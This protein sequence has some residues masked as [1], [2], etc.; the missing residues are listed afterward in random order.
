MHLL[1]LTSSNPSCTHRQNLKFVDDQDRA[2]NF[3]AQNLLLNLMG[4]LLIWNMEYL[5]I[6]DLNQPPYW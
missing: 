6:N 3:S 4:L 5:I 2:L 1:G